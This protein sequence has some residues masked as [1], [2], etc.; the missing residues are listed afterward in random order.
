MKLQGEKH[1][2]QFQDELEQP[3]RGPHINARTV[4]D[5]YSEFVDC[6][7]EVNSRIAYCYVRRKR[8]MLLSNEVR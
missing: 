3:V 2:K 1:V 5:K 4:Y 7:K 8:R 6:V